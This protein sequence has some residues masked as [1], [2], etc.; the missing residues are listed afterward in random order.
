[1]ETTNMKR[2]LIIIGAGSVGKYIAYNQD[3]FQ[4]DFEI[5]GFLDDDKS[6]HNIQIAGI[7]VLGNVS[8]VTEY[9]GR[10]YSLAWGIAFPAIK[11]KLYEQYKH[12]KFEYPNFIAKNAWLSK[13]ISLGKGCIIYPGCSINYETDI[14]DFIVINMNCAIGH[15]CSIDSF[16]SL[17]PGVNLGGNTKIGQQVELGIGCATL[18]GVSIGDNVKVGGQAMVTKHLVKNQI[19]KGVPAR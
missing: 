14:Q 2:K 10:G 16:T 5:V 9:S 12:L 13:G 1:M 19:V 11:N 17:S 15:N 6:K 4:Q 8:K 3:D 18:Q 7:A